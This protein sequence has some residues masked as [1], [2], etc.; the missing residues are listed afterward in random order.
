[1]R[2][3]AGR[4]NPRERIELGFERW[5]HWVFRRRWLVLAGM[6]LLTLL[7]SSGL[8]RL[9]FES[10][11][12]RFL[13]PRDPA[14]VTYDQFRR[15]FANDDTIV[16]LLR[17]DEIFSFS[18][19]E[20][21]RSLHRDLE[22][23]GPL[24]DEVNSLLN[25]RVTH[26]SEDALRVDELFED[27]PRDRRELAKRA[28]LARAN[29]LYRNTLLSRDSRYTTITVRVTPGLDRDEDEAPAPESFENVSAQIE[30]SEDSA[31]VESEA[32]ELAPVLMNEEL[33]A[34]MQSIFSVVERHRSAE[35][36][37]WVTG[38]PEMTWAITQSGRAEIPRFAALAALL[39]CFFL[40]LFFRR[41]SG[42]LL[43]ITVVIL[44]LLSTLGI[45]GFA[46]IPL[47][48]STQQLPSFLLA[49]CVGD[50]VHILTLFYQRY[51]QSGDRSLAIAQALGHSGLAVVMTSLTTAVGMGSFYFADLEPLSELGIAAPTGVML[52]LVHSAVLLPALLA[53]LPLRRRERDAKPAWG[54]VDRLLAALG[55][56][57]SRRPWRMIGLWSL[58]VAAS[59]FGAS[60]LEIAHRPLEWFPPDH[61]TRVAAETTNAA[62]HGF[63]P[64]ELIVDSRVEDGLHDPAIMQRIARIQDLARGL[65]INGIEVAQAISVADIVHETN[66]A[67]HGDDPEFYTVPSQRELLAQELLLFENSGSDDLEELVDS[68]LRKAR[69]RLFVTYTDGFLY[70]DL[71]NALR[72]GAREIV[73]ELADI[74]TTGLVELWLRTFD[75]MLSSTFKSYSIALLVI[76][77]LMILLIGEV[78]LGL[79]SLIPNLAPI[80]VGMALM[81][82]MGIHFDMY[83]M[84][85]G[86]IAIGIA[87]DDTIHF[88]HGF[89]RRYRRGDEAVEA[90]RTTLLSTGRALLITSLVLCSGFFVQLFATMTGTR[91]V[92]LITGLPILA[93]L[94]A[95]LTLSPALVGVAAPLARRAADR[96]TPTPPAPPA[97]LQRWRV[98]Q[99]PGMENALGVPFSVRSPGTQCRSRRFSGCPPGR[100]DARTRQPY[101]RGIRQ[102]P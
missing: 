18:F 12:D 1:M 68:S 25:A 84:M 89:L 37:I 97:E 53:V 50:S 36:P 38:N 93:A 4:P 24:V 39:I 42:V 48:P 71:V 80:I 51:N 69:V 72:D 64:L 65:S 28:R 14:R 17:S 60:R 57:S 43:P 59:I 67:L 13:D 19:L 30:G 8:A 78:R 82:M 23:E 31:R 85:I 34:V 49:V 75:A 44:P 32:I 6:L 99:L 21:L 40:A 76:A 98:S 3:P 100:G 86:S 92:G 101:A 47:T 74:Q 10:S 79:L 27:W 52:A 70:L 46:D 83:T 61:P 58:V 55:D 96:P 20:R 15:E 2:Q 66:Q 16:L 5:G 41:A 88:M 54:A 102:S 56:F 22:S 81:S 9:R 29:P 94:L 91:N 62:M 7:L 77:P 90:V 45:M 87:V 33:D 73:G 63:M 35:F 26:G 11:T 95:D